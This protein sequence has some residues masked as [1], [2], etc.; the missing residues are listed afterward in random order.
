MV[1]DLGGRADRLEAL[2]RQEGGYKMVVRWQEP[3]F[4]GSSQW[5]LYAKR[6]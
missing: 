3:R 5:M 6:G 1:H 2:L 4:R